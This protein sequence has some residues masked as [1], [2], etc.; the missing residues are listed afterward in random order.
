MILDSKWSGRMM[1]MADVIR[2]WSK[3]GTGVGALL[4]D[5]HHRILSVGYN[6]LPRGI[7]DTEARLADRAL[8]LQMTVHAEAN[9][10]VGCAQP[11]PGHGVAMVCTRM[12]CS[13][14]AGLI[15]QSGVS[16]VHARRLRRGSSWEQDAVAARQMFEEAGVVLHLLPTSPEEARGF[17]SCGCPG[18]FVHSNAA[19]VACGAPPEHLHLSYTA[20]ADSGASALIVTAK[21]HGV[22]EVLQLPP[23][24]R[25]ALDSTPMTFFQAGNP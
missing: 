2:T 24:A 18:G 8:K 15:I 19:C 12:P 5:S 11:I 23:E 13:T 9:A 3:D 6:G 16:E 20:A 1:Q 21:C 22:T 25:H 4:V 10:I 7:A 14:C 17:V